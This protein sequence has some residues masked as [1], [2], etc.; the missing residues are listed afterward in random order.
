MAIYG[1]VPFWFV[2][3]CT[4]DPKSKYFEGMEETFGL[5]SG[6]VSA[7]AFFNNLNHI[8]Q[9]EFGMRRPRCV[10]NVGCKIIRKFHPSTEEEEVATK[11]RPNGSLREM[12]ARGQKIYLPD[13]KTILVLSEDGTEKRIDAP[14]V[15]L[16]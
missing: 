14:L 3:Q 9:N 5:K 8:F 2:H 6:V 1:M 11:R 12:V 7:D 15:K 13:E 4:L 10:E 16:F